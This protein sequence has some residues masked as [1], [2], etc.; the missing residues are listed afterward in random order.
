MF[1]VAG[2]TQL[3]DGLLLSLP[4]AVNLNWELVQIMKG[5]LH[6]TAN[7]NVGVHCHSW[8]KGMPVEV[9]C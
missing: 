1:Q 8:G 3:I 7:I 5:F 6:L 9:H 4:A 2:Q